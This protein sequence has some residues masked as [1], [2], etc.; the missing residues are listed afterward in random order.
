MSSTATRPLGPP[1]T[2]APAVD[3]AGTIAD[4]VDRHSKLV[5]ATVMLGAFMALLDTTIVNVALPSIQHALHASDTALSWTVSGYAL[6]FGIVLI[7]AGRL[8]DSIG[9]KPLY[10][11]GLCLF[12]LA[13]L[14]AGLSQ[15]AGELVTARVAQGLG[16]G[17]FYTQINA[18]II[19]TFPASA[20]RGAFGVLSATIGLSTAAGP[21]A[22]GLLIAASGPHT[23]WRWVFLINV[24]IGL[25]A[26]PA[27]V[28]LLPTPAR[29]PR[30]RGDHAAVALLCGALML[31][32]YPLINGQAH[33]WPLWSFACLAASVA[34]LT[35]L[36]VW[37][38]RVERT[39]RTPLIPPRIIRRR[40][41]SAGTIFGLIYFASFTS[42]FF[43]LSVVWQEGLG[44]SALA[45]GL[46][47][48]PYALGSII[49]AGRSHQITAR[50]GRRVLT[51]GCV[52]VA[53][54]T[55]A[56]IMVV[57]LG[58]PDPNGWSLIAPLLTIGLGNGMIIAPNVGF[59]LA[60]IPAPDTGAASG[61]LNTGQRL[62]G[63]LGIAIVASVLFDT[64]HPTSGTP[65]ALATAYIHSFQT[66][67]FVNLGLVL[68]ALVAIHVIPQRNDPTV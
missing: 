65:E 25:V 15:S 7:P 49:T 54:G 37:E 17:I 35:I 1:A 38:L 12:L 66:A 64:L 39:G 62:G 50:L 21:L 6:A 47:C 19:D 28:L 63:A 34:M 32:L 23:G 24:V 11:A 36:A 57:H 43:T 4:P 3:T 26:V 46:L 8:G 51:A 16:A 52:T 44:H 20:R 31:I 59:T 42:I 30:E 13:S 61:V 68:L 22:G 5:L 27:A 18:T 53:V 58:S 9:R 48:T 41:F 2:T 60:E 45:T 10:T 29:R 56:L 14:A 55:A 67:T 40:S 33:G